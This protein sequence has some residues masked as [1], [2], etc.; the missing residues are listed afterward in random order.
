MS[1][2]NVGKV[3]L[4]GLVAGVVYNVGEAILNMGILAQDM[5]EF[6]RKY[7]L[8]PTDGSFIAKMTILMFVFGIVTV[9]IYAAI[10]PRFGAGLKTAVITGCLV[11]FLSFFYATFLMQAI[12]LFATAPSVKGALWELGEA[13]LAS[14]AGAWVYKES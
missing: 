7:Q 12:G 1:S 10:R 2:I 11:W 3:I 13:V 8:P 6:G 9:F 5:E 4:G 14:I